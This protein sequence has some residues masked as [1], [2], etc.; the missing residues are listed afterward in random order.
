MARPKMI[1]VI[2]VA[3]AVY[4]KRGIFQEGI[5]K[6]LT[7][8]TVHGLK[9]FADTHIVVKLIWVSTLKLDFHNDIM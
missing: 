9:Y 6:Y 2:K 5:R 8:T 3:K 1:K 4:E 7:E